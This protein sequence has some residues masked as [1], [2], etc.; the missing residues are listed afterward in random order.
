MPWSVQSRP[1]RRRARA[2]RRLIGPAGLVASHSCSELEPWVRRAIPAMIVLFIAV[3]TSL[4]IILINEAHDR[5]IEDAITDLDLVASDVTDEFNAA[6]DRGDFDPAPIH[7]ASAS[8]HV[9]NTALGSS[10]ALAIPLASQEPDGGAHIIDVRQ[11]LATMVPD[12][13]TTRGQRIFVADASGEIVAAFPANLAQKGRLL[14]RLGANEALTTFAEKAGVMRISLANGTDAL[15]TVRTL[16]GPFAQV[17]F[18]HPMPAVLAEWERSTTR[19]G[20]ALF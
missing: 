3:L 10:A 8:L 9:S 16:H 19:T 20:T 15:A 7:I 17:A 11:A 2:S 4:S 5:A 1:L 12:R 14:D 13:A 18:I 6:L